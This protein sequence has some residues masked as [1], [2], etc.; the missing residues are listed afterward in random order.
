[1]REGLRLHPS[2]DPDLGWLLAKVLAAQDREEEAAKFLREQ[3]RVFPR[4]RLPY[5]GLLRLAVKRRDWDEAVQLA[6]ETDARTPNDDYPGQHELAFELMHIPSRWREGVLLLRPIAAGF[7]DPGQPLLLLGTV[8]EN[9]GDP[10]GA[11]FIDRAREAWNAP[12]PFDTAL[13][14]MRAYVKEQMPAFR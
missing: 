13:A 1:L 2:A 3:M 8:L 7:Q 14:Q 12:I 6:D 4:S 10:E 5:L 11:R 9:S